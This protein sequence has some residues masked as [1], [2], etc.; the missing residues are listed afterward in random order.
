M[1]F[2]EFVV[3]ASELCGDVIRALMF[4]NEVTMVDIL[5][6]VYVEFDLLSC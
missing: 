5:F 4:Y 6:L 2:Y 1:L 3:G